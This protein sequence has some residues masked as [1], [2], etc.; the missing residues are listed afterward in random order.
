[1]LAS[2]SVLFRISKTNTKRSVFC[3][4]KSDL[5]MGIYSQK[6][7]AYQRAINICRSERSPRLQTAEEFIGRCEA[8]K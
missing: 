5:E 7:T 4:S 8:N 6:Y 1:M 3:C 2:V